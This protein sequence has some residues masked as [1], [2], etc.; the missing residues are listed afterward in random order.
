MLLCNAIES[1]SIPLPFSHVGFTSTNFTLRFSFWHAAKTIYAQLTYI[2]AVNEHFLLLLMNRSRIYLNYYKQNSPYFIYLTSI[3]V[4]RPYSHGLQQSLEFS[5][6][7]LLSSN[8]IT[9]FNLFFYSNYKVWVGERLMHA[10]FDFRHLIILPKND[11]FTVLIIP[12]AP[13]L[14]F[15]CG[16]RSQFRRNYWIMYSRNTIGQLNCCIRY[17]QYKSIVRT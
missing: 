13:R 8:K 14:T 15:N 6:R 9:N 3:L 10:P 12:N 11:K 5:I 16:T 2:V 7:L 4:L 17:F 1:A